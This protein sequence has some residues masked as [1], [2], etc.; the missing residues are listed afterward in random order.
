MTD[1]FLMAW[2][3]MFS[4]PENMIRYGGLTLILLVVFVETGLLIGLVIPGGDSLLLATGLLAGAQILEV[5]LGVLLLSMTAAG[6]AG[7]LLGY[8]IGSKMGK[9]LFHKQDTWYFKRKNLERAQSFYKEKGKSA[10][11]VGKFVPVVR[12]FNPLLA[13]VTGMEFSRFLLLSAVGTALWICSLVL[14]SYFLGRQFPQMKDYLHYAIPVII[15][16]SVLPGIIQ[17]LKERKKD[18][19]T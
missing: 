12:T 11:L 14:A 7:D 17:Y 15:F 4:S 5:P 19:P 3:E 18:I 16:L 6:V 9:R 10:I 13:G 1:L 2:S 8:S